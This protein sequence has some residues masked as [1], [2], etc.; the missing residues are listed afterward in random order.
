MHFI[1]GTVR[2]SLKMDISRS[3]FENWSSVALMAATKTEA[4]RFGSD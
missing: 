4:K 3:I 1:A 2:Q